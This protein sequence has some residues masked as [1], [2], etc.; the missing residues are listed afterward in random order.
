MH[1]SASSGLRI[2]GACPPDYNSRLPWP[3]RP[4]RAP[5]PDRKKRVLPRAT[6]MSN[7]RRAPLWKAPNVP[8]L[9]KC[10]EVKSWARRPGVRAAQAGRGAGRSVKAEITAACP[11]KLGLAP[12]LSSRCCG[13]VRLPSLFNQTQLIF[14][15]Q[16]HQR[17]EG[18]M[19]GT[20]DLRRAG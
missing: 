3:L 11:G 18:G 9:R 19:P 13:A 16:D 15:R 14:E 7:D 8:G 4:P 17:T 5:Q 20:V 2:V 1:T 12:G 6:R 10:A